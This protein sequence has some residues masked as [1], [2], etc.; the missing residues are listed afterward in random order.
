MDRIGTVCYRFVPWWNRR[1]FIFDQSHHS[2]TK[3]R[4]N[5]LDRF[6]RWIALVVFQ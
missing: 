5:P 2:H 3:G 1:R 4:S 6:E